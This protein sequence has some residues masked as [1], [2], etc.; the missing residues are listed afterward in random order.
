MRPTKQKDFQPRFPGDPS[1]VEQQMKFWSSKAAELG[2]NIM[3]FAFALSVDASQI[4][5][6]GDL[7][8]FNAPP[9]RVSDVGLPTLDLAALR[10]VVCNLKILQTQREQLNRKKASLTIDAQCSSLIES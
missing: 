3:A 9:G 10:K 4:L 7:I 2:P 6:K 1:E 8:V 5:F